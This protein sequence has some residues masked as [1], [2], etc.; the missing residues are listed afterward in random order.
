MTEETDEMLSLKELYETAEEGGSEIESVL[1]LR[2][3]EDREG[4][5]VVSISEESTWAKGK[6]PFGI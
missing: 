2:R 4:V 5:I 3:L 6:G 1:I